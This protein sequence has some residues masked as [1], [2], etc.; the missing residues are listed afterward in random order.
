MIAGFSVLFYLINKYDLHLIS[1]LHRSPTKDDDTDMSTPLRSLF[2]AV[3]ITSLL[4]QTL[5]NHRSST[6]AGQYALE[7]YF[8]L[9]RRG[10]RVLKFWPWFVGR[11]DTR[12]G[13]G[14]ES[15]LLT[16]VEGIAVW[17]ALTLPRVEQVVS[18]DEDEE[19]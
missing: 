8:V 10:V 13:I 9:I 4:I 15:V 5:F 17:Q 19:E 2:S 1:P 6:F 11:Y 16:V 7:A 14:W 12:G 3:N 18:E